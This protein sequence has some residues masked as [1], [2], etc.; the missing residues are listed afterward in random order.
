MENKEKI[1]NTDNNLQHPVYNIITIIC[2]LVVIVLAV[3]QLVRV[4]PFAGL[5][6]L[7]FMFVIMVVQTLRFWK[8]HKGVAIFSLC[9]AVFLLLCYAAV[10][11]LKGLNI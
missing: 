7:P 11:V 10:L 4:L 1:N 9:V 2:S 5:Y 8:S 6:Y 3:L